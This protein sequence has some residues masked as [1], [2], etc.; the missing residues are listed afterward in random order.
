M[1]FLI[2]FLELINPLFC[3]LTLIGL[4]LSVINAASCFGTLILADMVT[5]LYFYLR[6]LNYVTHIRLHHTLLCQL[7]QLLHSKTLLLHLQ[8]LEQ[9]FLLLF[10]GS[11]PFPS[12]FGKI[13][14]FVS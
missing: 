11:C 5:L 6:F 12:N 4:T 3:F 1:H 7:Y 9:H 8:L 2:F 10:S 13:V 14:E